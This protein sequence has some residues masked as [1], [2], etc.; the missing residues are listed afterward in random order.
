[1]RMVIKYSQGVTKSSLP[2]YGSVVKSV[3]NWFIGRIRLTTY[4]WPII[5]SVLQQMV[6]N[7]VQ[8][9]PKFYA[10]TIFASQGFLICTAPHEPLAYRAIKSW[11]FFRGFWLG[12]TKTIRPIKKCKI[13]LID[14]AF[15]FVYSLVSPTWIV[16]NPYFPSLSFCFSLND[17]VSFNTA[18]IIS[19]PDFVSTVTCTRRLRIYLPLSYTLWIQSS[20]FIPIYW[21]HCQGIKMLFQLVSINV[22]IY[23]GCHN[24]TRYVKVC[25]LS[26]LIWK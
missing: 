15:I 18:I 17:H 3:E 5:K 12:F 13:Y 19:T 23:R 8:W 25:H 2:V 26:L 4:D 11:D 1:M 16:Q 7:S 22:Y 9:S 14:N 20:K 10:M 6:L 21:I 24:C